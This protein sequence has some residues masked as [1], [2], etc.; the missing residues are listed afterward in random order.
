MVSSIG[1]NR[2]RGKF[3]NFLG[4]PVIWIVKSVFI[5]VKASLRWLNYAAWVSLL[6]IVPQGVADFFRYDW[7]LLPIG[8]RIVQILRQPQRKTTKTAPT[9]LVQYKHQANPR[10]G[11]G[12]FCTSPMLVFYISLCQKHLRSF[13]E[14]YPV[15]KRKSASREGSNSRP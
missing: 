13:P 8:W 11:M 10:E 2:G 1:L 9:L 15:K 5:T 6:L 7:P 12:T 14:I 4:P 3:Q